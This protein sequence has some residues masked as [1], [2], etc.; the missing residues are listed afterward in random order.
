MPD[1]MIIIIVKF[2]S[3]SCHAY[4]DDDYYDRRINCSAKFNNN[5]RALIVHTIFICV[6]RMH[7]KNA[8]ASVDVRHSEHKYSIRVWASVTRYNATV[9]IGYNSAMPI[10][11]DIS[12]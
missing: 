10:S 8:N 4:D 7:A 6:V 11:R 3:P 9:S 5:L 12:I 1:Q 2:Y